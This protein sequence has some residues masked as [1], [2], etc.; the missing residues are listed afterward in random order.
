MGIQYQLTI[1]IAPKDIQK[2]FKDDGYQIIITRNCGGGG[3][4]QVW[5][6]PI[7]VPY[8]LITWQEEYNLFASKQT[9]TPN[10][11][12]EMSSNQL[13][14]VKLA[15]WYY[16][17]KNLLMKKMMKAEIERAGLPIPPTGSFDTYISEQ[18]PTGKANVIINQNAIV[19]GTP[20]FGPV[21][22]SADVLKNMTVAFTP[23]KQLNVFI[24]KSHQKNQYNVTV[25]GLACQLEYSPNRTTYVITFDDNDNQF[26]SF[27]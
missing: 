17:N 9:L 26:R 21:G 20:T 5:L 2:I 23:S 8:Q 12:I 18:V 16:A 15:T 13:N 11:I 4:N 6:Q 19:G 24:S 22:A 1:S 7:A 3:G 14:K 27:G 10:C 25:S